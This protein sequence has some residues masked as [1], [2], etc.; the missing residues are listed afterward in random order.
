[1]KRSF[2]EFININDL[3]VPPVEITKKLEENVLSLDEIN[4]VLMKENDGLRKENDDLRKENDELKKKLENSM[5]VIFTTSDQNVFCS[6]I[7]NKNDDFKTVEKRFYEKYQDYGEKENSFSVKNRSI[8][9]SKTLEENS[10]G[11]SD[12]ITLNKDIE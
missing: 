1:M 7:C 12:L 5:T 10:I 8:D 3:P 2:K 6:L 4:R 9:K 11:D